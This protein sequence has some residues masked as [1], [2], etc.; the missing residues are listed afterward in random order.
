MGAILVQE[1]EEVDTMGAPIAV[2]C[3]E[4]SVR[5]AS[6]PPRTANLRPSPQPTHPSV[7]GEKRNA[8]LKSRRRCASLCA[9][10]ADSY[11]F[12]LDNSTTGGWGQAVG[13][14]A[15]FKAPSQEAASAAYEN[16][17]FLWQAYVKGQSLDM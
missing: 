9:N 6:P 3:D 16:R 8:R 13:H 4:E 10:E 7:P 12:R 2:V 14:F 5:G 1:G 15:D 11:Q 17:V